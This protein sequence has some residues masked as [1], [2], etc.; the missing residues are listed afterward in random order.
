MRSI[1]I[2]GI[3]AVSITA[4]HAQRMGESAILLEQFVYENAP[5]PSCHASTIVEVEPRVYLTAFFGGSGEGNDDVGIWLSRKENGGW[6]KPVEIASHHGV[7]CWNPVLFQMPDGETILFYKAGPSPRDWSGL[8]KR[9]TDGGKTWS[10]DELLPAGILGPIRAKPILLEDGT[11]LCG[12]SVESWQTWA[13][14][15]EHTKDG[16]KT[17][18]K[19]GPIYVPDQ[20]N[21]IIQPTVWVGDDDAI[22]MLARARGIGHICASKST[23][24]GRTWTPAHPIDL[25]NPSA[26]IDAVKLSDGRVALIYNHTERGRHNLSIALSDNDG[27]TWKQSVILENQPKEYSYPAMIEGSDGKLHATYTYNREKIKYVVVDP[28]QM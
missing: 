12:S 19:S 20:L 27:E 14:W 13:C 18:S 8:I 3:L 5:F 9:S 6:S 25:P 11:L 2:L 23:D 7:P 22:H 15:M 10:E 4:V 17:W 24:K 16:G 26:G 28:K 21:G 1:A